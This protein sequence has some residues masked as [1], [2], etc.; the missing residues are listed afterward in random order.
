M[1]LY[2]IAAV[3]AVVLITIPNS[4]AQPEVRLAPDD[5]PPNAKFG[6]ALADIELRSCDDTGQC[7]RSVGVAIGA[8][9]PTEGGGPG[10]AYLYYRNVSYGTEREDLQ[11]KP[12]PNPAPTP[13]DRF[14]AALVSYSDGILVI[15]A[16][17]RRTVTVMKF[18]DVAGG[19]EAESIWPLSDPTPSTTGAFGDGLATGSGFIAVSERG[20]A[21]EVHFYDPYCQAVGE[22]AYAT[23]LTPSDPLDSAFGHSVS[24]ETVYEGTDQGALVLVSA[25]SAGGAGVLYVYT[26]IRSRSGTSGCP[27]SAPRVTLTERIVGPPGFGRA[28][29]THNIG[30]SELQDFDRLLVGLPD[31]PGRTEV[32]TYDGGD[33]TVADTIETAASEPALSPTF[34]LTTSFERVYAVVTTPGALSL[35]QYRFDLQ[36]DPYEPVEYAAPAPADPSFGTVLAYS[37]ALDFQ[38]L[39]VGAPNEGSGAVYLYPFQNNPRVAVVAEGNLDDAAFWVGEALPNPSVG[40]VRFPVRSARSQTINVNVYD[41]TGRLVTSA[42]SSVPAG[43]AQ[44]ELDL[45]VPAGAYLVRLSSELG[46]DGRVITVLGR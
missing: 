3:L 38:T 19:S 20:G 34:L 37:S 31:A 35:R 29:V 13:G 33:W 11:V 1:R 6:S 28:A 14:G 46:T 17:G 4:T 24:L 26:V 42:A 5:L 22:P 9:G 39:T 2:H 41:M 21:G 44:V 25:T 40:S 12:V 18:A 10:A 43:Q 23:T 36:P 30:V 27:L 16:P 32:R 45:L 7:L 15:G 8:P